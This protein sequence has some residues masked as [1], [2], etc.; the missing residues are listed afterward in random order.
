MLEL[1]LPY[2]GHLKCRTD[3]LKKTGPEAGKD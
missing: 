2:L 3:S 1:K